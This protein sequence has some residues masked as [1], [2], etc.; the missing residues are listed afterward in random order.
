[1]YSEAGENRSCVVACQLA[2]I[3]Q[4]LDPERKNF[5]YPHSRR[6]QHK[7]DCSGSSADETIRAI[8][9][10]EKYRGF[11]FTFGGKDKSES[12]TSGTL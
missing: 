12:A 4:V 1:M 3:V 5:P 11:T 7:T 8:S 6:T 9:S 2:L 10:A